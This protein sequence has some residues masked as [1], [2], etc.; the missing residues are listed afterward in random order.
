MSEDKKFDLK[1]EIFSWVKTI[2]ICLIIA[3]IITGFL[4]L[5]AKVPTPSMEQTIMVNDRLIGNRLYK[6]G[7][8]ER[9]DI[10]VFKYPLDPTGETIYVKRLIGL[11]GETIDIVDGI[12]YVDGE[13]LVEPYVNGIPYG[14][15][16]PYIVPE[17]EYFMLG[18]NRNNSE[19]S[20]F[21]GFVSEDEILSNI[22]FRYYP[23]FGW[24][25]G[26]Y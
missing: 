19:D 21:W 17:G 25:D 14:S 6:Y 7:N 18:D 2:I 4:I 5:N 10:V 20:R 23:S 22:L 13:A 3:K 24:L 12:V 1:K 16:G 26:K 9:L 11:P 8:H 15:F